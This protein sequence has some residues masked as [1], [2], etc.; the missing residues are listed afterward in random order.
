MCCYGRL[1]LASRPSICAVIAWYC[2]TMPNRPAAVRIS[3]TLA[4]LE[5]ASAVWIATASAAGR[6][7]LVPLSLAW[8]EGSILVATP[9]DTPTAR[10]V[11]ETGRARASLD[12]ANDVVIIAG[13]ALAQDYA[14]LDELTKA[15]FVTQ[16]GWDP[17]SSPG[18]W[19]LLTLTPR[20]IHAWRDEPEIKGRTI[21]RRGVWVTDT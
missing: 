10:N 17:A 7:H 20:L 14:D 9:T 11:E 1:E 13:P 12:S 16:I 6:P 3:D 8:H 5:T 2:P 19:S 21:M 18:E 4:R 15:D